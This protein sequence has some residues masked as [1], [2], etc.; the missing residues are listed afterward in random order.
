MAVRAANL[1]VH[2]GYRDRVGSD[3]WAA[4][5]NRRNPQRVVGAG[6]D[7]CGDSQGL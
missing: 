4:R 1:G 5:C 3:W 7:A 2:L 6:D